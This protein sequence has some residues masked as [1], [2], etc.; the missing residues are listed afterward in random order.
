MRFIVCSCALALLWS[1]CS[2]REEPKERKLVADTL[3]ELDLTEPADER[4]ASLFGEAKP[5]HFEAQQRVRKFVKDPLARGLFVRLGAFAGHFSDVDDWAE[6]FD[7]FRAQKKPVHCQF[8]ELDNSGYALA[9]HCD[10]VSMTPA[11]L[12]NLVGLAAQ[13]L[14]GRQLLD[15][16]GV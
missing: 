7:A 12:L 4:T 11:G 14:H 16:V 3:V 9:S 15:M 10:L 2:Q 6:T 8:D 1:G 13:V 5:S